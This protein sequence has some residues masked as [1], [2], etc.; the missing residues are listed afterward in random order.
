MAAAAATA[1][2]APLAL[3]AAPSASAAGDTAPSAAS[4]SGP[5]T[6]AV[7]P[8][9]TD[10]ATETSE[11]APRVP[12]TPADPTYKPG[13]TPAVPK[14]PAE[15]PPKP[16]EPR[17]P[18]APA[19]DA[20]DAEDAARDADVLDGDHG[21]K[22]ADCPVDEDGVDR[23]SELELELSGVPGKITP[24]SG[25]HPFE[26]SVTNPTD[27]PLGE[28]KWI[29]SVDNETD[30][31]SDK[32]WLSEYT[33]L[34][35]FDAETKTWD[36]IDGDKNGGLAFD[37]VELDAEETVDIKLRVDISAKAPAGKAY[38]I[39]VGEYVDAE[40]DCTHTSF[41][42]EPLTIGRP[43]GDQGDRPGT[44][45]PSLTPTVS[46]TVKP[47]SSTERP[48]GSATDAP[49][50][51]SLAET[52]SSSALPTIALVGGAAVVVGAGAV[53]VVRRRK[54]DTAA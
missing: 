16:K 42:E 39:G 12:Q 43:G 7:T 29:T 14:P 40:L 27:E 25:W 45:G 41:S 5:A 50:G 1:A 54:S 17:E 35:F 11:P 38:T 47:T 26:L 32:D 22:P 49:V 15:K 37:V 24:G 23:D 30:G 10:A 52:G 19:G 20:A 46:P 18:D 31:H 9:P 53:L 28:V 34:Q 51:G 2:L 4:T 8:E 44:P 36:S 48:Q 3:L 21:K 6:P 13:R 33:D